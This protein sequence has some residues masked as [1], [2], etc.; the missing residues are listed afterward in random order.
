[1]YIDKSF[2]VFNINIYNLYLIVVVID[3]LQYN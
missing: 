3:D 1:M 2:S